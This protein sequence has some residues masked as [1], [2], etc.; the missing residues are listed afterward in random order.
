MRPKLL[1]NTIVIVRPGH[2][3]YLYCFIHFV[4]LIEIY[5]ILSNGPKI[6]QNGAISIIIENS[7]EFT[8]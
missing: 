3:Y 5:P 2:Y 8:W 4:D 7:K 6:I 1:Y